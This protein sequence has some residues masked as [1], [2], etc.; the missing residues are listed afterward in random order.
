MD[1]Y[2][3]LNPSTKVKRMV[4]I[5]FMAFWGMVFSGCGAAAKTSIDYGDAAAFEA[6]LNAGENLEG[7]VVQFVALELHPDSALGYNVWAGEHLNFIS[8]RNPD[9]KAGDTAVVKATTIESS[10]GSWIITYEKVSDAQ[11]TDATIFSGDGEAKAEGVGDAAADSGDNAGQGDFQTESTETKKSASFSVGNSASEEE[12]LPLEIVDY[13][14]YI[15]KVSS[16]S[17]SMY[18]DFCAMIR[19]PNQ[20]QIAEFPKAIVTVKNGDGSIL[21]TED[22]T[23]SIVMPQD[24]V[25]LCGSFSMPAGSITED[26]QIVFDVDWREFTTKSYY[27]EA[28]STTDFTFS[29]VSERS[30]RSDFYITG[31]ITNNSAEDVDTACLALVLRKDGQIVYMDNTFVHGLKAG[32]T[33]AFEMHTYDDVPA[34]DTIDC[35][36]VPW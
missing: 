33:M 21:A 20:T 27:H 8:G 7:K 4:G 36:A 34:H 22:Q 1:F 10:V 30:G 13:G 5:V 6:A 35:S 3:C 17:D 24:T 19:N 32:K 25:T 11:I 16:Y 14:W 18:V 29:N 12:T 9:I 23:G 15:E 26:A 28:V 31:E 2:K